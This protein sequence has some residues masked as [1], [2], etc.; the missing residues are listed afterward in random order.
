MEFISSPDNHISYLPGFDNSGKSLHYR[1]ENYPPSN[2]PSNFANQRVNFYVP[3]LQIG[4][5]SD[6]KIGTRFASQNESNK[7][8]PKPVYGLSEFIQTYW[9]DH[10][11][12]ISFMDNHQHAF[13][14]WCQ[15]LMAKITQPH[16]ILVHFDDHSDI[17]KPNNLKINIHNLKNVH[18]YVVYDLQKDTQ[19]WPA[20]YHGIFSEILWVNAAQPQDTIE[21]AIIKDKNG[22]QIPV[23][24]IAIDN[25][26]LGRVTENFPRS[27]I[28]TDLC[29]DY[30][31]PIMNSEVMSHH[32]GVIRNIFAAASIG[33]VA[34]SPDHID[35]TFVLQQINH[36]FH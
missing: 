19:I 25:P 15:A 8:N 2:I 24:K 35:Q 16:S 26:I 27:T 33:T 10:N 13:Y 14:F 23:N 22:H 30:F 20:I 29:G 4:Q 36:I 18:D 17:R 5:I 6:L 32:I 7:S 3:A 28:V 11:I 1:G 31:L 34:T 21:E 12:P 9:G